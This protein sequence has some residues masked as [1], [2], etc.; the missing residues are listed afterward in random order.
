MTSLLMRQMQQL[1][2]DVK[3]KVRTAQKPSIRSY[4]VVENPSR[5]YFVLYRLL[6]SPF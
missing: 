4:V 6:Q 1:V 3:H 2:A 5:A